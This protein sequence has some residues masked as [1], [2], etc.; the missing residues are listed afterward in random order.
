M[1]LPSAPMGK[2]LALRDLTSENVLFL[3][4]CLLCGLPVWLPQFPPMVD[5]PQHAA[6][7][8]LMLNLHNPEFPYSGQY[9]FDLFTPY[10]LGYMLIAAF[11]PLLGIVAACKL[12]V[13]LAI[14]TYALA[15]RYLL[16]QT[17]ADPY[18]SWL[19]FPALYG[20]AYQWGFLN[21]LVAAP[22]GILFL[23][24]IWK[25]GAD[26]SLRSSLLVVAMLYVLFFC[27]ALILGLVCLLAAGYWYFS[28]PRLR[29]FIKS[30]WP[31]ATLI[32]VV[33]VWFMVAS[34]DTRPR[35]PME[36]DLSWLDTTDGYYSFL[37]NWVNPQGHDWGRVTGFIPRLLGVRP[38]IVLTLSG[39]VMLILPFLGGG[40]LAA[41][42]ER[43]WPVVLIIAVLLFLPSVLYG[44]VFTVQR[45]VLL[46][47][48][49]FLIVV[50]PP[51]Q[52]RNFQ[53]YLRLSAPLLAF[54]WIAWMSFNALKFDRE[55]EGFDAVMS[56][57]QPYRSAMSL[58]FAK[59]DDHSI[60]PTFI[61][62]PA[63]Y[64]AEKIG[65]MHPSFAEFAGMPITFKREFIPRLSIRGIVWN[66]RNFDWQAYDGNK[67]DYF[68][69]R[70]PFDAGALIARNAN[71]GINL[72]VH[73]G[74]WWLYRKAGC[75]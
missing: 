14:S 63:W 51:T 7:I 55:A 48:P 46:F 16:R 64:S 68:I 22:A 33:I 15:T 18:W 29:E 67:Y 72:E 23:G 6:Q 34:Q 47:M 44:T 75:R 56:R 40:R 25:R 59:D 9:Q 26:Q 70:A 42:R 37:A 38:S 10:L 74:V 5:L 24:L 12:V 19:V 57:M 8:S 52:V 11:A 45:F 65:V 71:C 27:H 4:A 69:V 21:F 31:L 17:G 53:K 20:F 50:A 66:P 39:V 62:F 3:L 2:K 43:Y 30:A 13:W 61:N 73:S 28:A 35:N 1:I 41:S 60:A 36:W 49:L 58:V 54:G 32:P